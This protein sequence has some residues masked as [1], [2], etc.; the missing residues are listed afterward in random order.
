MA[1]WSARPKRGSDMGRE[2]HGPGGQHGAIAGRSA[3]KLSRW[4]IPRRAR[5]GE[6]H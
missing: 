1:K 6:T 3:V 4:R 5:D 2:P